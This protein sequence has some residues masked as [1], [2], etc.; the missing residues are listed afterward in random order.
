MMLSEQNKAWKTFSTSID[1]SNRRYFSLVLSI[2]LSDYIVAVT[3]YS[4]HRLNECVKAMLLS[5]YAANK[6]G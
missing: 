6:A 3:K 5:A 2:N 1:V 4:S